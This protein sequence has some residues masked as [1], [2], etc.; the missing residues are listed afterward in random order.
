MAL[1]VRELSFREYLAEK[2]A[3]D[4][5]LRVLVGLQEAPAR[6]ED[7]VAFLQR[8]FDSQDLPELYQKQKDELKAV[9]AEHEELTARTAALSA[10]LADTMAQVAEREAATHAPLLT[11][12]LELH[13]AEVAEG[14]EPALSI[15]KLHAALSTHFPAV[16][17][18]GEPPLWAAAAPPLGA[19]SAAALA[20]WAESFGMAG[21]LHR[22]FPALSLGELARLAEPDEGAEPTDADTARAA[23]EAC[24]AAAALVPSREGGEE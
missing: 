7:P 5:L 3:A 14:S 10:Q 11:R 18:G 6:P 9:I 19:L 16:E 2:G 8:H 24:M 13:P 22:R 23:H 21:D 20:T 15:E 17:E 1:S 4:A 12:L